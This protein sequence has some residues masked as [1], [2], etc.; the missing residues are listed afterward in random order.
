MLMT[1][2][3]LELLI[4]I[5]EQTFDRSFHSDRYHLSRDL[6]MLE[7][8][9]CIVG[10]AQRNPSITEKGRVLVADLVAS[11]SSSGSR[12]HDLHAILESV[13]YEVKRTISPELRER[14]ETELS[15]KIG[16]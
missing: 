13:L 7:M 2:Y 16:G 4:Q 3:R 15:K 9:R 5:H 11:S 14:I 12:L 8:D 10:A 1:P 6:S